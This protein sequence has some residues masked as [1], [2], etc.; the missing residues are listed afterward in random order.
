MTHTPH[1]TITLKLIVSNTLSLALSDPVGMFSPNISNLGEH[2]KLTC[3][4]F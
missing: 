3:L 1:L 4:I 2:Y